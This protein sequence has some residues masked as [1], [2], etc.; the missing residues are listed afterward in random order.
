MYN[1]PDTIISQYWDSPVLGQVVTNFNN[2]VDPAFDLEQ[3]FQYIWD[4]LSGRFVEIGPVGY[5]LDVWGRIVGVSRT[6]QVSTGNYLG[7]TGAPGGTIQS[8][9]DSFD[10]G[11][12]YSGE[13]VTATYRLADHTYLRLILAKAAANICNG[14]IPAIN[15]ILMNILFPNRGNCFVIDRNNMQISYYF[16]F[17]LQNYEVSIVQNS[18]VL[19]TPAGVVANFMYIPP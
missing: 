12:F 17:A 7:L 3:F 19:P 1:F 10:Y 9:G 15:F 11:I 5:G 4:V 16:N 13:P 18:N 14:S 8:S 6:L 2:W